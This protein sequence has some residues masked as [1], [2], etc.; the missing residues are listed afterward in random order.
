MY[1]KNIK[2]D[3]KYFFNQLID[4]NLTNKSFLDIKQEFYK[5]LKNINVD[6]QQIIIKTNQKNLIRGGFTKGIFLEYILI[7]EEKKDILIK[8]F[9][10]NSNIYVGTLKINNVIYHKFHSQKFIRDKLFH[11]DF[12]MVL[13]NINNDNYKLHIEEKYINN[14]CR[15]GKIH[16]VS[17]ESNKELYINLLK[18]KL[19]EEGQ[20]VLK[21]YDYDNL[22][23]EISDV[24]S[25]LLHIEHIN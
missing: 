22:I 3:I 21:A 12:Q 20:E 19:I 23:E 10:S 6:L 8:Y 4:Y 16:Y 11:E 15:I 2:H 1:P 9:F 25:I 5:F 17:P 7:P 24:Y 18:S 13:E 14:N